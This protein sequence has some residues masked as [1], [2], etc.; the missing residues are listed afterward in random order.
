MATK[1]Q[2]LNI[3]NRKAKFD[4]KISQVYTAGVSLVGTEVKSIRDNK[5]NLQD[6]FA[7]FKTDTELWLK[8][9]HI[10]TFKEGSYNNHEPTRERQLLLQKSELRKLRTKG[11][12]KGHTI[13]LLRIFESTRGLIKFEI[14]IGSG[15]KQYDKR[16]DLKEKDLKRQ[17]DRQE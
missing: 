16:A 12:E 8:G 3:V 6:A 14:G 4:Y 9:L 10:S 13:V 5:V 1:K 15:K 2:S 7:Y 17:I 11:K